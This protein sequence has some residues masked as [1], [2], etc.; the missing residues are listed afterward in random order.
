MEKSG[1][2]N[3]R[4]KEEADKTLISMTEMVGS[5]ILI[6]HLMRGISTKPKL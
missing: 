5:V 4:I 3:I 2:T 6:N 1:D